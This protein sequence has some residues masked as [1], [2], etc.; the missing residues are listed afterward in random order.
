MASE[1][2]RRFVL[3]LLSH[4]QSRHAEREL[5]REIDSHLQLL[6]E[7]FLAQGMSGVEA[8]QAARR[9]FG[10]VDQAKERQRDARS[11]RWLTGW[12]MDLRLGVRMLVKYPGL[13]SI[14]VVALAIAIGAGA[15]YMEFVTDLANPTLP[16]K[17]ADR[18]VGIVNWDQGSGRPDRRA[19]HD[20]ARWRQELR[21]VSDL[22]AAASL[23]R[24]LITDDG[25]SEPV[26]GAEVSAS[27]FR[28]IPTAPLIGRSLTEDDERAA[29]PPVAVI[30]EQLW[31]TRFDADSRILG[32][33]IRL[34]RTAYIVV[35][36]MPRSFGFPV[37]QVLWVPL[38]GAGP[39]FERGEGPD[40]T[41]FGRLAPGVGVEAAQAE[42]NALAG[43]VSVETPGAPRLQ[44]VIKPYVA[45]IW[46]TIED[47]NIQRIVLYSANV[48]FL[49]L[50][51]ICGANVATLVFARV[52]TREA[53][54][55]MRT[56][57]GASRGRIVSQLFAEALVLA[58]VAMAAGLA[59]ASFAGHWAKDK[60]IEAER[61]TPPFWWSD[62][63]APETW[64]YAAVLAVIAA[65]LVG[66][67]PALKATGPGMQ[68]RLKTAGAAGPGM[69]FGG[70]WTVVIVGQ[71]AVTV[72][73][74]L[75]VVSVGWNAVASPYASGNFAFR[76]DKYLTVRLEMDRDTPA[77]VSS[78]AA[79]AEDQTRVNDTYMELERRLELEPAVA[80][81]T[82]T[83]RLPGGGW[84]FILD[85]PDA[86]LPPRD[87]GNPLWVR[88][89]YVGADFFDAFHAPIVAGRGFTDGDAATARP[90]A[91]VD[92]TFVK[93]VLGGRDPIGLHVREKESEE[94]ST[95][96]SRW[97]E[98]VGVVADLGIRPGKISDDAMIY[99]PSTAGAQQGLTNVVVL[100]RGDAS[101]LPATVARIAAEADPTLRLY[102]VMSLTDY[103]RV[104]T[105]GYAFLLRALAVVSAVAM[106]LSLAG[107]YA[108]MSFTLSRRRREIGIRA[109]LGA[110]PRRIVTTIFSRAFRQ[111]AIGIAVG[112]VPGYLLL[113]H[114][115]PEVAR[116]GGAFVAMVATAGV[117]VFIALATAVACAVPARRALRIQP[118]E[119]LRA[120]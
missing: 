115:A 108:L 66:V 47:G 51:G 30:G 93:E 109:A 19:L 119:A 6:E 94:R 86:S 68:A 5:T 23:Q 81:V 100:A 59:I 83:T 61:S 15:A 110:A 98:I 71:V 31:R 45:S 55:T 73:F 95:T 26:R 7:T 20:V 12:S 50:L 38:Q 52:V 29:A 96:T 92:R 99:F 84:Q 42:L 56:A 44:P 113:S 37:N 14:A 87:A 80:A 33:R 16:F 13:T 111:V 75:T 58:T 54:I 120:E 103:Y 2:I 77:S 105:I 17:D 41:V 25:R 57:L 69:R 91:I 43:R 46:S 49:A 62:Q 3:R 116:G 34:A 21:T 32:Q 22:G 74:L 53:E 27:V 104:E 36:V 89:A 72:M 118:T 79:R 11:F 102:D 107:V 114:G 4:V 48:L 60:F 117:V 64:L 63:L 76:T 112:C 82:H 35:G 88:S 28:V 39:N 65:A 1:R 10:G 24:N 90:V 40:V 97:Y 8:R 106:L 78:D 67:V 9:A 18:L 101:S 85:I 70:V